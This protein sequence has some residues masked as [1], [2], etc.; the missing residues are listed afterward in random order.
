[1]SGKIFVV[2]IGP[3]RKEHMS[4]RAIEVIENVDIIV[5]YK[6]KNYLIEIKDGDKPTTQQKLTPDEVKFKTEWQGQY[7]VA[8]SF[9]SLLEIILEDEL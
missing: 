2:G 1:M 3:G 8:N 6:G 4:L 7:D 5:G 9:D